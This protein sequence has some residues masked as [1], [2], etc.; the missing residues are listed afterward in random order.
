MGKKKLELL[1]VQCAKLWEYVGKPNISN[2]DAS[3]CKAP[4]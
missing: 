3:D 1:Q 4:T 2:E